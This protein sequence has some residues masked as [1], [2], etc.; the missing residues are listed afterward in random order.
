MKIGD[1]TE[2]LPVE[3]G[4]SSRFGFMTL[5]AQSL[6]V[7]ALVL[8]FGVATA[9]ARAPA[10]ARSPQ[11]EEAA[12]EPLDAAELSRR[13]AEAEEPPEAETEADEARVLDPDGPSLAERVLANRSV[14]TVVNLLGRGLTVNDDPE[15]PALAPVRVRVRP[16]GAGASFSLSVIF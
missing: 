14:R 11:A 3:G 7:A 4:T 16:K 13:D 5:V 12:A 2:K 1:V 15:E 10:H 9:A 6:W 8:F